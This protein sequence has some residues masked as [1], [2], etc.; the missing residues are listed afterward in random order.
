MQG[1]VLIALSDFFQSND[2]LW[3]ELVAFS[4]MPNHV[5][6]LIRPLEKLAALMQRIKGS[7]AKMINEIMGRSGRF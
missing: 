6:L 5:H 1:D 3:C 2:G 4:I 7:S